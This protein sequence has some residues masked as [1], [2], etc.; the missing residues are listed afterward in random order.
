MRKIILPTLLL[1]AGCSGVPTIPGITPYK[2]DIQQGNYVTQDMVAKLKPG[3]TRPQVRFILGTP[4]VVDMFRTNRWDYVYLYEKRGRLTEQRKMTVIFENDKLARIEGDVVPARATGKADTGAGDAGKSQSAP[5]AAAPR[6]ESP[7]AAPASEGSA[8]AATSG[9]PV[10]TEAP[11]ADP[12]ESGGAAEKPKQEK[13]EEEKEKAQEDKTREEKGF[14][15]RML[16]K[17][18]L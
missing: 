12:G 9:E 8:P 16:D 5:A 10:K 14:F 15:G 1:L 6:P 11:K 4:L 2:I 7:A 18:G 13:P 3:M 17:I